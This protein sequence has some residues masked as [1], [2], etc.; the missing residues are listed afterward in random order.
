MGWFGMGGGGSSSLRSRAYGAEDMQTDKHIMRL[1]DKRSQAGKQ[2]SKCI[3]RRRQQERRGES[4]TQ[5]DKAPES[6][7]LKA[8]D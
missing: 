7:D 2:A 5:A 1:D 3:T 8:G 6:L 4:A